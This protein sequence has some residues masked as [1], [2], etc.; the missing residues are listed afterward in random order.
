MSKLSP[1]YNPVVPVILHYLRV[2]PGSCTLLELVSYCDDQL[3]AIVS[4]D[5]LVSAFEKNFL[6]MNGLYQIQHQLLQEDNLHLAISPM[7][8]QVLPGT[9]TADEQAISRDTSLAGYYLDWRN[10]TE[11]SAQDIADLLAGFWRR[12]ASSDRLDWASSVLEVSLPLQKQAVV[13]AYR[14]KASLAHPDKGGNHEDFLTLR[15][16]YE[17]LLSQLPEGTKSSC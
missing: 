9:A 4:E 12:A 11:T 5:R 17:V 7:E 13:A 3:Q 6:V 14:A 15:E 16:A 8:I 2:N 10:L 1:L